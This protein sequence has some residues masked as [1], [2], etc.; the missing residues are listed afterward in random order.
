MLVHDRFL[1]HRDDGF[2]RWRTIAEGTDK[3]TVI[4]LTQI[5][6]QFLESENGVD[7]RFTIT[8]KADCD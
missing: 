1:V 4:V 2:G 6:C 5:A 3:A 8:R 7:H